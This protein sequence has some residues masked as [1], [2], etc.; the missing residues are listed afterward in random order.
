MMYL[1]TSNE[2]PVN[3]TRLASALIV[4]QN[5]INDE[6]KNTNLVGN[7]WVFCLFLFFVL[8]FFYLFVVV[9]VVVF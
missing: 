8:V 2:K 6:G 5:P 3:N 9:V 4:G 7:P 1:Y